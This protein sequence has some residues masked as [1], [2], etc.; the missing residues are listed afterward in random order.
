[1]IVFVAGSGLREVVGDQVAIGLTFIRE[2]RTLPVYRLYVVESRFA[3]LVE[4]ETGGISVAGE[5]CDLSDERAAALLATEPP[6]VKQAPVK[7]LD[8]GTVPGP[9]STVATLPADSRDISTYG[10]FAPYWR[11]LRSA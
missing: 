6:G 2:A 7:L 10:G 9:V 8:G 3:A 5:L 4:V 1:M 11:S